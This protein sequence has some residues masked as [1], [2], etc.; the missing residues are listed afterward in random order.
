MLGRNLLLEYLQKHGV[1]DVATFSDG[2]LSA[3]VRF[4]VAAVETQGAILFA[5]L[6]GYTKLASEL[7]PVECA[8]LANHFFAW[9]E[10]EAGRRFGGMVDKFIGDEIMVVFPRSECK[11]S[12]L[13]AAM[14]T[15][16]TMLK[17][18]P[19]AFDPKIGIA[20]GSFAV[21]VVGTEH[22]ASVSAMGPA[23]N[24]AARCTSD[25]SH[26]HSV[27]IATADTADVSAVFRDDKVWEVSSPKPF[28]PQ[29]MPRVQVVDVRR[30]TEFVPTFDCL[31]DV[32]NK[33]TFAREQGAVRND[34]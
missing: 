21:S 13:Q 17:F 15:A 12:P 27:K 7:G 26:R 28:I 4:P 16:R 6:P 33:V 31:D 11:L 5:D 3:P 19:Y 18:D 8:C 9:F 29:N 2:A 23:V 1:G 10:G 25:I 32:R 20:S 22:T 14:K 24:L 34:G 30:M